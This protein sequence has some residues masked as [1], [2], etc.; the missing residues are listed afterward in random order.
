MEINISILGVIL[1]TIAQFIIG[2]VWY[3]FL[4][5]KL[6]GKIHGFDK[7]TPEVQK[8]MAGK[9]GPFYGGQLIVTVFTSVVLGLLI[10]YLPNKSP[11]F[12]AFLVWIGFVVPTQYSDVIFG[13]T[14]GKWIVKKLLV[15]SAASLV[16]LLAAAGILNI[17]K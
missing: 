6:W 12:L 2:A 4:F 7:L 9:M 3:S 8:E 11:F 16:C 15:L 17:F 5:G 13:G 14:E 1:A 10:N